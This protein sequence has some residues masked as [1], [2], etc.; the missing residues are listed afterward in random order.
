M[1]SA[2]VRG[3]TWLHLEDGGRIAYRV[4][5]DDDWATFVVFGP[6]EVEMTMPRSMV[7]RCRDV[8]DAA[9]HEIDANT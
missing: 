1:G 4:R 9:L 8:F 7:E 3:S 6:I 2:A 5:P